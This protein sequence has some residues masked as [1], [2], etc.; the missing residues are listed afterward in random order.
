[1]VHYGSRFSTKIPKFVYQ[2][3]RVNSETW[4]IHFIFTD[5]LVG[6]VSGIGIAGDDL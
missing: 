1:M 2:I 3:D 4:P 5:L 6:I